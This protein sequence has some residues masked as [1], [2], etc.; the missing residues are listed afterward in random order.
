MRERE[1]ERERR[2]VEDRWRR[3][4]VKHTPIEVLS[5]GTGVSNNVLAS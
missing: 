5:H 2:M 1:R 4:K 3:R